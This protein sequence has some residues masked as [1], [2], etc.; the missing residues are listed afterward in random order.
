[1]TNYRKQRYFFVSYLQPLLS[2]LH[3]SRSP[4]LD[5]HGHRENAFVVWIVAR[6]APER[7]V[8]LCL[9]C[10][11]QSHAGQALEIV[12]AVAKPR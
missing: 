12:R 2:V 8:A 3:L 1:M 11:H 6:I 7:L 9:N 5:W 10:R 4:L